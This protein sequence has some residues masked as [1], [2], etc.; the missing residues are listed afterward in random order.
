[1][2][3]QP[4]TGVRLSEGDQRHRIILGRAFLR[5]YRLNYDGRTGAVE[6]IEP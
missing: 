2:L 4:L 6:I 1:L 5:P 3:F